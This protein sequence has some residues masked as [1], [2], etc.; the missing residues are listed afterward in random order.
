MKAAATAACVLAV[1][2]LVGCGSM[3][4]AGTDE[5]TNDMTSTG[6]RPTSL[7]TFQEGTSS[8]WAIAEAGAERPPIST[9]YKVFS[10]PQTHRE[11]ELAARV[12]AAF[13][14][15]SHSP[16]N[17]VQELGKPISDLTRILLADVGSRHDDLVAQ[18]AANGSIAVTLFPYGGGGC[19]PPP[20][21][22]FTLTA[23]VS[24]GTATVYG[25]VPD[26]VTGVVL[27][28]DDAEHVARLGENG[29]AFA[30]AH[31]V[32]KKFNRVLLTRADGSTT[33][34]PPG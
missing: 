16:A 10:R 11:A 8:S 32:G 4:K 27:V 2:F 33:E 9:L 14:C 20:P 18:P 21:D 13:P 23:D 22:G 15:A 5:P 29:F 25:M 28:V 34:I 17:E 1:A 26:D 19:G 7:F 31:A 3:E 6:S 12:A 24:D 30:I